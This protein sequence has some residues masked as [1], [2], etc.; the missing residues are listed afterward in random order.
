MSPMLEFANV[1]DD[2]RVVQGPVRV[3][4]SLQVPQLLL[5]HGAPVAKDAALDADLLTPVLCEEHL[6]KGSCT[7]RLNELNFAPLDEL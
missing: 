2:A 7:D 1:L 4:L 3:D 6:T 5:G